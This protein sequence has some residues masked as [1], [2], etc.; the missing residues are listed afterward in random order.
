M[1]FLQDFEGRAKQIKS[2]ISGENT[3]GHG[4][5]THCAGTVGSKT[6]GVAKKATIYGVKVLANN[7]T[8]PNS[9]VVSGMDFVAGDF[10]SRGCT[11]GTV[12]SMSLGGGK[13]QSTNDAA[14][15]LQKAGVFVAV[16][17]GNSNKDASDFSPASEPS[18]CTV[19]G[20]AIDDNRYNNSNYGKLVDIL[21]PAVNVLSTWIGKSTVC[22]IP[23]RPTKTSDYAKLL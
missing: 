20:T 9:G 6:Y 10:K 1:G 5:G 4:H 17:A 21:A 14:A 19:G 3:D 12:A 22:N 23:L 11:K 2:F 8:G 7:G 16:A 15:K 18:V 13:S